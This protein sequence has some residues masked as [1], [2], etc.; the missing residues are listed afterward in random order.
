MKTLDLIWT[1]MADLAFGWID[2]WEDKSPENHKKAERIAIALMVIASL[3]VM[4]NLWLMGPELTK[5]L[6]P[7]LL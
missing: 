5:V 2:R 6:A 4:F 1:R 7:P 3:I